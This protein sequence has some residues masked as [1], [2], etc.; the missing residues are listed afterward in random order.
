[1]KSIPLI[2]LIFLVGCASVPASQVM[3]NP[4]TGKSVMVSHHSW[5]WGMA[6]VAAAVGA[7]QAQKSDIE[8]MKKMGFVE[9]EKV[10]SCGFIC[11]DSLVIERMPENSPAKVAGMQIGD[12]ITHRNGVK[13]NNRTEG[14]AQPRP[15]VNEIVEWRVLRDGKPLTFNVRA[16]PITELSQK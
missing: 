14:L 7:Q 2:F 3:V 16:I 15:E 9:A 5:G 13:I 12:V 4:E 1:M 6:G 11:S 8:A 10:A